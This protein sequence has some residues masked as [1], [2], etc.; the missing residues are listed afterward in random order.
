MPSLLNCTVP[1]GVPEPDCL[2][3][4][5]VKVIAWPNIDGLCEE[6]TAVVVVI[7]VGVVIVNGCEKMSIQLLLLIVIAP[8][9]APN[10]T[11]T[12]I[13]VSVP[14]TLVAITLFENLTVMPVKFVPVIVIESPIAPLSG[15]TLVIVGQFALDVTVN[16]TVVG[17]QPV[18]ESVIEPDVALGGTVIV[19]FVSPS[20]ITGID[21]APG[22]VISATLVN[23]VPVMTIVVPAGPLGGS[24]LLITG[25]VVLVVTVNGTV[26]GEQPGFES[27]IEPG[28][29]PGGTVIVIFVSLSGKM[30]IE[31]D[32]GNVS[33]VTFVKPVPVIVIVVPTG[34]LGGS[35]LVMAGQDCA[36]LVIGKNVTKPSI[37]KIAIFILSISICQQVF[38]FRSDALITSPLFPGSPCL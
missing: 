32:P 33:S 19:I 13:C 22:N 34:P 6:L 26:V 7:F 15:S 31:P 17:E 8:L 14:V 35:T 36:W 11:I 9:T 2:L 12:V 24:T 16:G 30:G 38:G 27:V 20:G 3:T 25:Q 18:F 5:A 1:E 4:M 23:P 29:V 10:G 28:V 21:P 37:I